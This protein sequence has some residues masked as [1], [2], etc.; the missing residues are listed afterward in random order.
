MLA[1][2]CVMANASA[3]LV[4]QLLP[5]GDMLLPSVHSV[6]KTSTMSFCTGSRQDFP[7]TCSELES[8]N[9]DTTVPDDPH[10]PD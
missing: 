4:L 8:V 9:V 7:G 3:G 2:D 1:A 10:K 6:T 5:P